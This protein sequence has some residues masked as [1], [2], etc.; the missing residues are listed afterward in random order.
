MIHVLVWA[1]FALAIFY[2]QPVI[3]DVEMPYQF[4]IKQTAELSLLVIAFYLNS[5][6]LV[7]RLLLRNRS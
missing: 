6:L 4:W 3:S 7:P 2:Y 5:A 1:V